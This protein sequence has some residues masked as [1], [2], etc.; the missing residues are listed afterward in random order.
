MNVNR[1]RV[2][3]WLGAGSLALCILA[4][5]WWYVR[6]TPGD[7]RLRTLVRTAPGVPIVFT[8]RTEPASFQAAAPE[9]TGYPFPGQP[10]WQ[11]QEGRLRLLTPQGEVHELTWNKSLPDGGSLI[12]VMSP[13]LS[14]DSRKIVFAGRR[15]DDH[16][17]FRLYEIDIDGRNL[18]PLTGGPDDEGCT[19][20]PPMRYAADGTTKLS[21]KERRAVDYDDV[22]PVYADASNQRIVFASSRTPDLGRG[23]ARRSTTLW[24]LHLDTG[25]KHPLTANRYNDRWPYLMAS[26][27]LAFS[28]W[29]H[30][31]EVIA[32]DERE[33]V[34]REPGKPGATAP[35]DVWQGAFIQPSGNQFGSLIKPN[36]P[37]W[38]PRPLFDGRIVFMTT[39]DQLIHNH[40]RPHAW[41][42][43]LLR[44][45]SCDPGLLMTA[46]SA[47]PVEALLP[48]SAEAKNSLRSPAIVDDQEQSIARWATPSPYPPHHVVLSASP[49]MSPN[50]FGLYLSDHEQ[51]GRPEDRLTLLFDDPDFIDAE[52][53]AVY[54]R[55]SKLWPTNPISAPSENAPVEDV[56]LAG[57]AS[58]RGSLGTLFNSG[59]YA[60]Q[61]RDSIGQKTDTG[62]GPIFTQPPKEL[63]HSLRI[64]ASHRDRFDDPAQPRVAGKWELLLDV[65]IQGE[66]IGVRVPAG[67]PTVLAC[68]DKDG[69]VARW[70]TP[71]RDSLGRQATFYAFA[72]DHYSAARP[73]GKHFCIGCHPG[74]SGLARADHQ[75][76]EKVQ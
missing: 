58:F 53:V 51:W 14:V 26:N 11:A 36:L 28:M 12:D 38:R 76:A 23:H 1:R 52:P 69:K 6:P 21:D 72:G 45:A 44:V 43:P 31:Q 39:L 25:K 50:G 16:G 71:A 33:I 27:F 19:A 55:Q 68:F 17:H 66:S 7:P 13:T 5:I 67:M 4:L 74:H 29:S 54:A 32:S 30:N 15:K 60:F 18:H 64:Y 47:R 2:W 63:L 56:R 57:G 3:K 48:V 10:L 41:D 46:P 34:P 49:T 9:G 8:S 61:H 37:V 70:K 65:P 40:D 35:A 20:V 75:H 24:M 42:S 59:L 22:D 62:D 73:G